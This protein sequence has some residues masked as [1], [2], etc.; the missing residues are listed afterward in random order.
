MLHLPDESL[1]KLN[2]MAAVLLD[3]AGEPVPPL[4]T[5]LARR[6]P[7][8]F[9]RE[10]RPL[11]ASSCEQGFSEESG[12]HDNEL[13]Y[14]KNTQPHERNAFAF[15]RLHAFAE[16]CGIGVAAMKLENHYAYPEFVSN[17]L[18]FHVK[19]ENNY[20]TLHQQI[21]E[22]NYRLSMA[23]TNTGFG[24]LA[25][26]I[27]GDP[28]QA[29]S[30]AYLVLFYADGPNKNSVGRIYFVLPSNTGEIIE[31]I[32][33]ETVIAAYEPPAEEAPPAADD[34]IPLPPKTPLNKPTPKQN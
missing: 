30:E 5:Y 31:T 6:V 23:G 28:V 7:I 22:A 33:I 2:I 32:D 25:L 16:E 4:A 18:T 9:L 14:W 11:I 3:F 17:G 8:R 26:Q 1:T 34:D 27:F 24:Q 29:P 10:I 12:T 20:Q 13:P 15:E 19:H 21:S